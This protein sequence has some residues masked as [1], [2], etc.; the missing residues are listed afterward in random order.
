MYAVSTKNKCVRFLALRKNILNTQPWN[1]R[2][3]KN[4]AQL[5]AE[6][7]LEQSLT[8]DGDGL[9][10]H[11]H[12]LHMISLPMYQRENGV[13]VCMCDMGLSHRIPLYFFIM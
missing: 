6:G 12:Y 7:A 3:C 4:C 9:I 13:C 8:W 10:P 2:P 5:G 1:K 11:E